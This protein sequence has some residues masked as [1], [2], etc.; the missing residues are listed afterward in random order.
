MEVAVGNNTKGQRQCFAAGS[1]LAKE[2]EGV[3]PADTTGQEVGV[4]LVTQ[5]G[6]VVVCSSNPQLKKMAV[7]VAP[8]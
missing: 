3:I 1:Q 8:W 2:E 6:G 7:M 4:T 5:Q